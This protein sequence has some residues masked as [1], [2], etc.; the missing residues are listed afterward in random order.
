MTFRG[1]TMGEGSLFAQNKIRASNWA[2]VLL[3]AGDG[4]FWKVYA[5]SCKVGVGSLALGQ[6][7]QD[8][9]RKSRIIG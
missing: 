9:K 3:F 2:R 4:Q 1:V 5:L 8:P 7:K 6:C